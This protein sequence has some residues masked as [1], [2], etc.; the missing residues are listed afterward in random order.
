MAA[1]Q[2]SKSSH[3][4]M[5]IPPIIQP[6]LATV[7]SAL[8]TQL[9]DALVGIYLYGSAVWGDFDD[10]ISDIDLL[11]VLTH[12][13]DAEMFARLDTWHQ[14]L[15]AQFP[16][17]AGRIEIAYISTQ[18]LQTFKTQR[19]PIAVI[20]PGE[21]FN[22]KDAGIDW[23]IN[24]YTIRHQSVVLMGPAPDRII[25]DIS[26]A[27]FRDSVRRQVGEWRDWVGHAQDSRPSQ[28]Y[29]ILTMCRALYAYT[30]GT[31]ASKRVAAEWAMHQL[32]SHASIITNA[33]VWRRD[34]REMDINHAA[35]YRFAVEMVRVV[36]EKIGIVW[37]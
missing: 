29:V 11:V 7:T 1:L 9:G 6:V 14:A 19:S 30:T 8:P 25:P 18:A 20:S 35:T 17:W 27:E 32:P 22:I 24:W 34:Y 33:L 10:D 4:H 13:V 37:D 12:D 23:L 3:C 15:E 5:H 2:V 28:A 16:D 26:A 36:G 21:P 31:Q